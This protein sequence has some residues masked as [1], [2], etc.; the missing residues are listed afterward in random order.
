[1]RPCTPSRI[2][3]YKH[4]RHALLDGLAL[5]LPRPELKRTHVLQA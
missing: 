5:D 1:M 3:T 4:Q 2:L